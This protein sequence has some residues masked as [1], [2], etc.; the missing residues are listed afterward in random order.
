[1]NIAIIGAGKI[2]SAIGHALEVKPVKI[3]LWDV[4]EGK[5]PDQKPLATVLRNAKVVFI[6]TPSWA[7]R[8][9][10]Q[11]VA[12]HLDH[13]T[14][15]VSPGKGLEQGT[16]KRTDEIAAEVARRHPFALL[17]G[18]MLSDEITTGKFGIGALACKDKKA[19]VAIVELFSGTDI[20]LHPTTDT[21]GAAYAGVLKNVYAMLMGITHGLSHGDNIKGF[22]AARSLTEMHF[23]I[24]RFGGHDQTCLSAAGAGDFI[25]T[26][27]SPLS[28]N[29]QLGTALIERKPYPKT[30]EGII[31][32]PLLVAKLGKEVSNYPVL[33]A[34]ESM[35][36][37]A[38]NPEE[39]ITKLLQHSVKDN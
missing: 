25:S 30:A 31:A 33:M 3:H 34:I 32:L 6:C 27:Y 18:S 4:E 24:Q 37:H 10:L 19:T 39:T 7:M 35:I 11:E 17:L 12:P 20:Y 26:A 22:L 9:A 21:V 16:G 13:D 29:R 5:V 28:R 23:L 1:M 14:I 2:G 8:A 15:I 36:M 38:A